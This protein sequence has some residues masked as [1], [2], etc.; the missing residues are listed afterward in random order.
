V[1][2]LRKATLLA[3]GAGWIDLQLDL[4]WRLRVMLIDGHTGRQTLL[5]PE[6]FREPRTW[7]LDPAGTFPLEGRR[8]DDLFA[9]DAAATATQDGATLTLEGAHLRARVALDPLAVAW[10]QRDADGS[11]RPC[12][13]DRDESYA[14]GVS[15]RCGTLWHWQR[16]EP[17]H[18]R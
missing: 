3:T 14:Y 7:A 11:W 8:R 17:G 15:Q 1:T 4:G 5:P 6:G 9:A 18:D 10:D 12:C 13:A 16:R 2:P